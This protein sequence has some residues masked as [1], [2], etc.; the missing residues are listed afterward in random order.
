MMAEAEMPRVRAG[1]MTNSKPPTPEAG[2]HP[3]CTAKTNMAIRPNQKLGIETPKVAAII[4]RVSHQPPR[5]TA[6]ATPSRT[7]STMAKVIAVMASSAV[8]RQF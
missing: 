6:A 3:N 2:N 7:P 1:R 8:N 4:D 5:F